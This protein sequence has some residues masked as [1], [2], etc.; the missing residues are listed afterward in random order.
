MPR[1][2]YRSV[3]DSKTKKWQGLI[4][5]RNYKLLNNNNRKLKDGQEVYGTILCLTDSWEY[6]PSEILKTHKAKNPQDT[7]F[8]RTIKGNLRGKLDYSQN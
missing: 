3:V 1:L 5:A 6:A 8:K 2:Y 4:T 7:Y